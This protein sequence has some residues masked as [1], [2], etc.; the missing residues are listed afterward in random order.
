MEMWTKVCHWLVWLPRLS[1]YWLLLKLSDHSSFWCRIMGC[2][3]RVKVHWHCLMDRSNIPKMLV[4]NYCLHL[5]V[6]AP[7]QWCPPGCPSSRVTR[8]RRTPASSGERS[9]RPQSPVWS[10]TCAR[11]MRR[12]S[13]RCIWCHPPC[14]VRMGEFHGL[15]LEVCYKCSLLLITIL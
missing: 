3:A 14:Q 11:R 15:Y 8:P 12:S 4:H 2:I 6:Q 13:P 1:D 5:S 7:R 10:S 9:S